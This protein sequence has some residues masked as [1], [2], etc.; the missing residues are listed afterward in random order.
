VLKHFDLGVTASSKAI[1]RLGVKVVQNWL[2]PMLQAIS[3]P[4]KFSTLAHAECGKVRPPGVQQY[5]L[6]KHFGYLVY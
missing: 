1:G 6:T 4:D 5:L 2:L 3:P